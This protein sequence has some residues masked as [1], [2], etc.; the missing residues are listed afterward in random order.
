MTLFCTCIA[1][2]AN[3]EVAVG[4]GGV[5]NGPRGYPVSPIRDPFEEKKLLLLGEA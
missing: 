2:S 1:I 5:G 3:M 4:E